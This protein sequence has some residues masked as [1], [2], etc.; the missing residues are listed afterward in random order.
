MFLFETSTDWYEQFQELIE[1]VTD[2]GG[3]VVDDHDHDHDED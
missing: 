3:I 2:L 1:T